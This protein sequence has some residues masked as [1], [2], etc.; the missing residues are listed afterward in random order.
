LVC[1][2]PTH[3][4]DPVSHAFVKG[5][6]KW[7]NPIPAPGDVTISREGDTLIARSAFAEADSAVQSHERRTSRWNKF[8]GDLHAQ[9]DATVG[10]GTEEEY[11]TFARD[12]ARLDLCSHQGNDFQM[13]DED[14]QRLNDV[15]RRFHRDGSFVAFP[16][17]NGPA[18]ARQV[19]TETCG[20]SM[21]AGRC[22]A[23]ATGR[24]QPY[25]RLISRRRQRGRTV[26][27]RA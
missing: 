21:R 18:T 7:G 27:A 6:D 19:G 10:T 26:R 20:S 24:C 22:S 2:V 12:V 8:W 17:G 9:S 15:I 11:F 5:Q 23:R 3:S 14:W 4:V 16:A 1:I 25:R 13:T